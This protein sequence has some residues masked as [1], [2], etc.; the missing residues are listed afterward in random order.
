MFYENFDNFEELG[1]LFYGEN[2]EYGILEKL[3]K[4][5]VKDVKNIQNTFI[6][7]N[8]FRK[9]NQSNY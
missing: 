5:L 2:L 9:N 3:V 1:F 8:I 7:N 6:I 4:N